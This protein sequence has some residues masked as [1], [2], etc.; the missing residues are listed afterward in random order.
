[1]ID[2]IAFLPEFHS[3][4]ESPLE[5]LLNCGRNWTLLMFRQSAR[6]ALLESRHRLVEFFICAHKLGLG[7]HV[8]INIFRINLH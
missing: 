3:C 4:I 1:M 5:V 7:F 8:H 6:L 2:S